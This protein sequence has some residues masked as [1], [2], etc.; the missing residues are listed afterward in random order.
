M[1]YIASW[2]ERES[3]MNWPFEGRVFKTIEFQWNV[4]GNSRVRPRIFVIPSRGCNEEFS[5]GS[6]SLHRDTCQ[7]APC[8][9]SIC[10]ERHG[11]GETETQHICLLQWGGCLICL[12]H[13]CQGIALAW[14][15]VVIQQI[16]RWIGGLWSIWRRVQVGQDVERTISLH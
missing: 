3:H 4:L 10:Q 5:C 1:S 14:K 2:N 6:D 12:F 9:W 8:R 7:A 15:Q 13:Q 16:C 11:T